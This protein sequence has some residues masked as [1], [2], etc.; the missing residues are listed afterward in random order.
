MPMTGLNSFDRAVHVANRWVASVARAFGTD[1]RLFAYRVLRAWLHE[2]RDRLPP[3]GAAHFAAQL[4]ELLRGVYYEGWDPAKVPAKYNADEYVRRFAHAAGIRTE[5]VPHAAAMVTSALQGCFSA[6][7]LSAAL[8]RLPR[9]LRQLLTPHAPAMDDAGAS[10]SAV[11]GGADTVGTPATPMT[12]ERLARLEQSL[13]A[14]NEAVLELVHG[15]EPRPIEEPAA[16]RTGQAA[17]RAHQ[18]LLSSG[19]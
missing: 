10:A 7:G 5:Q 2:L 19:R 11:A 8:Q 15:L 9:S 16:E 6:G 14:L 3:E 4:P 1:D 18:I 13:S 12:E 17:R